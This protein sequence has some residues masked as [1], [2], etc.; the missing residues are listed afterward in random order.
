P[1]LGITKG[2]QMGYLS[3]VAMTLPGQ[4]EK[5]DRLPMPEP[6]TLEA[7][8]RDHYNFVYRKAARLAGPGIDPE[9]VAQEVFLV[10]ARRLHTYD[11]TCQITTWL[12]GITLNVV[13][14]M[15]RGI[16]IR[17][18]FEARERPLDEAPVR[19]VDSAEA[20]EAHRIAY[21]ILDKMS[22]KK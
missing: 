10:V 2:Y 19:S 14:E 21:A 12:Y 11:R 9:D 16:R 7:V 13:R 17:R 18:L 15:R 4:R 5:R 3:P 1:K 20:L 6:L 22:P 8:F